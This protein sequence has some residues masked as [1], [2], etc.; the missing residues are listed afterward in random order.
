MI[1]RGIRFG[2]WQ[3]VR[4]RESRGR[5]SSATMY[6]VLLLPHRPVAVAVASR[7]HI[8]TE[9]CEDILAGD[10]HLSERRLHGERFAETRLHGAQADGDLAIAHQPD[11]L[12]GGEP[13]EE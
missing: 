12:C 2:W 9:Q 11:R 5:V 3:V 1:D 4:R 6:G 8:F 10:G 7:V 13:D